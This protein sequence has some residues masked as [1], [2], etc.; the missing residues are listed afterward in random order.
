MAIVPVITIF[1][2]NKKNNNYRGE[3][4]WLYFI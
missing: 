3:E 1:V 4:K 2:N